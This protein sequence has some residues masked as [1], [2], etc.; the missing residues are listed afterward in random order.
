MIFP[1]DL[2]PLMAKVAKTEDW[3]INFL[4][5][6]IMGCMFFVSLKIKLIAYILQVNI[7]G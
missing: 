7:K 5:V 6:S 2:V 1:E 3:V 4:R